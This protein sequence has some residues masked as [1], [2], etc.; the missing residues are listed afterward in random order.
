[1]KIELLNQKEAS[2]RLKVSRQTIN[3]WISQ[4]KIDVYYKKGT[5]LGISVKD[6]DKIGIRSRE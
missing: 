2:E 1:M 6:L 3:N 4:G 5:R